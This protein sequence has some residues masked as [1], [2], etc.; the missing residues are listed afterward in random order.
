MMKYRIIQQSDAEAFWQLRLHALQESPTAFGSDYGTVKDRPLDEVH[1]NLGTTADN[2]IFGAF[3][4]PDL[5]G[6]AGFLRQ[7]GV[8]MRHKGEI[9]GMYLHEGY[10]RHG[11]ASVLLDRVITHAKAQPGLRQVHLAVVA[12]NKPAQ[13]LYTRAGF[14]TYGREPRALHVDGQDYDE[15]HMVLLLSECCEG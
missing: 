15:D 11:I 3:H 4:G 2:C 10:R 5:I 7:H 9:W 13:A 12:S 6:I 8:K 14:V 1:D